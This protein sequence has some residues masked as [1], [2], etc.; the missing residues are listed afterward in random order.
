MS[1]YSI[2]FSVVG[3]L[4]LLFIVSFVLAHKYQPESLAANISPK[5]LKD[6]EMSPSAMVTP[7]VTL[8][9]SKNVTNVTSLSPSVTPTPSSSPNDNIGKDLG[10]APTPL[11]LPLVSVSPST[12]PTNQAVPSFLVSGTPITN[13]SPAT[14]QTG[15]ININT[16][17][18]NELDKIIGVGPATAQSIIGYRTE[19]GLF[20]KIEDIVKV[21]GIGDLK[22]EKMKDQITI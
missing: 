20:Q 8:V 13:S 7:K 11:A 22:F 9:T 21:K 18:L 15:K 3:S 2:K 14:A 1:S 10:Q 5:A 19:H 6:R 4:G 12:N 16:A 17:G